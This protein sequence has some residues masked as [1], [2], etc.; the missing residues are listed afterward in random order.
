[1]RLSYQVVDDANNGKHG[2]LHQGR[3]P[4]T[5]MVIRWIRRFQDGR[6]RF[7]IEMEILA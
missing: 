4:V 7:K 2:C 1:M 6:L 5:E 3:Y